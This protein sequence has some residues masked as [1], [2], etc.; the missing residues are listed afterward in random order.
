MATVLVPLATGFEEIEAVTVIDILR[1]G[2]VSVRVAGVDALA[3]TGAHAITVQ[4][5]ALLAETDVK[6]LD[7]I[8]LPGGMPGTRNLLKNSF[9]R[10]LIIQLDREELLLA[11]ICAAPIVLHAAGVLK[12]KKA[13]SYPGFNK[14]MADAVYS[15][16]P[17]VADGNI[18]TSRAAG[19]AVPFALRV[20]E[21]LA[22]RDTAQEVKKAIIA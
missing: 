4:C 13:T 1:R 16:D 22:G 7:G 17:V 6:T 20:L 11:A 21:Q 9:L 3:V 14:E 18:I 12:G 19:T 15:V 8:M 10:E 2:G 5:D